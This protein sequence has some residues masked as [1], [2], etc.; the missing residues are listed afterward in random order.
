VN[1]LLLLRQFTS[2]LRWITT[3]NDTPR[4]SG[5]LGEQIL[6]DLAKEPHSILQDG[7][8]ETILSLTPPLSFISE[9]ERLSMR[10]VALVA[11]DGL[12]A[13]IEELTFS[14]AHPLSLRRL[15]TLRVSL[16]IVE[17]QLQDDKGEWRVL[18]ALWDEQSH[19]FVSRL[20]D[21]F[22]GV[23]DDL[24]GHFVLTPP[25]MNQALVDE[26]FR[27]ADDLLR[28]IAC[29]TV[30]YPLTSRSMR[31]LIAAVAD[32]F[33]CTDAADM[34]YSQ[35]SSACIS[36]QG[37]RQTCLDIVRSLSGP[38]SYAEPGK[39]GAEIALRTLLEHGVQS[40]G[41]DPAYHLLQVFTMIDHLLPEPNFDFEDSQ[42]SHWVTMVL[43]NVLPETKSF[44]RV[45]DAENKVHLIKR[46]VRLDDG[47]IG[48]GEWL[49]EEELKHLYQTLQVLR[50]DIPDMDYRLVRQ[51]Q[52]SL[53]LRFIL[54]LVT[55]SSSAS[56][57]CIK[58]IA[59][60]PDIAH[61]LTDCVLSLLNHR[62]T[63]SFLAPIAQVLATHSAA[64][65]PNLRFATLVALLRIVQS[66]GISSFAFLPALEIL[67]V[68]PS[69]SIT[70]DLLR[71]EI[72]RTLSS[73]AAT[74]TTLTSESSETLLAVLEWLL[75]QDNPSLTTL[76][77]I[78][79]SHFSQ[80]CD[81]MCQS[82]SPSKAD[83]FEIIRSKINV[84]ENESFCPTTVPLPESL[85]LSIQN[86][87]DLL[88]LEVPVPSTP[89]GKNTPDILG[90]VTLSP[91][92]ALLRSPAATGLTKTY[93]NN[94]FRQLRQVASTRQNTSRLPSMHVVG[95]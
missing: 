46:L 7:L 78:T 76:C 93:A 35:S 69:T 64:F 21:I 58:S 74:E 84:E 82:L 1:H 70:P 16:A 85:E 94:D 68:L 26:L 20:V 41:R 79:A 24:N 45:L 23:T 86:I 2:R 73:F 17:Q 32:V 75:D 62:F 4:K 65:D 49:F 22:L 10:K 19:G 37:T 61:N 47:I 28:Q 12:P 44:F 30:A 5:V 33:A 53:S 60:I 67:R 80:L 31:S 42:Q 39:L 72:G 27:T 15:R 43:P 6:V 63:S 34:L 91:P 71:L 13:A 56:E 11:D 59:S 3:D 18:Q 77:G 51:H 50:D 90:L 95:I 81:R 89:K 52:V 36:A 25:R 66:D 57:W 9:N 38:Q 92:M 8:V 40:G 88:H 55:P 29:L 54:D 48:I 83:I 87:E 14:S